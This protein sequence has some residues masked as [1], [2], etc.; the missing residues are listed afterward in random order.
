MIKDHHLLLSGQGAGILSVAQIA[1]N[2]TW[3]T[4][5]MLNPKRRHMRQNRNALLKKLVDSSPRR[6]GKRKVHYGS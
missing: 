3:A 6:Y 5:F 2:L 4:K 1:K